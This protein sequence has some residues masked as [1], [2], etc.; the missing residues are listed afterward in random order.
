MKWI[1][2]RSALKKTQTAFVMGPTYCFDSG[3]YR[4]FRISRHVPW[5]S[6]YKGELVWGLDYK[7][8]MLDPRY[9]TL[10]GVKAAAEKHRE[11]QIGKA[12]QRA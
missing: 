3:D 6:S 10:P 7:G 5:N 4:I 12:T 8:T 9:K 2:R 1:T 11:N